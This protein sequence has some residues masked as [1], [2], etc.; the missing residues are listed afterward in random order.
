[1][2]RLLEGG[3]LR[4]AESEAP[5][6]AAAAARLLP[7]VV[8]LM[9]PLVSSLQCCTGVVAVLLPLKVLEHSV[10]SWC[11]CAA[12]PSEWPAYIDCSSDHVADSLVCV[13]LPLQL[14]AE[15]DGVRYNASGAL[16][17]LLD[18]CATPTVMAAMQQQQQQQRG[19]MSL[20]QSL[21]SAV[22]A[23]LGA[24][25]QEAWGLALPGELGRE[26]HG[27]SSGCVCSAFIP[28]WVCAVARTSTSMQ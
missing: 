25:Y 19:G 12:A 1:M 26:C 22:A 11:T 8:H 15:Q 14:S 16:R 23:A 27:W 18:N 17:S 3:L 5:A 4:L 13:S 24:R 7:R 21:V 20:L 2:A 28:P 10:W 6:D 9:V